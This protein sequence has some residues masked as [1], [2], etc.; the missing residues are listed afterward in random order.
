MTTELDDDEEHGLSEIEITYPERPADH[1]RLEHGELCRVSKGGRAEARSSKS[2]FAGTV[3]A[4][5]ERQERNDR[6]RAKSC[7]KR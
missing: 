7:L 5:R 2:D 4:R 1:V 3:R 6:V